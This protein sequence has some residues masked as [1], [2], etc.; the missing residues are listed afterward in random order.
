MKLIKSIVFLS[1][2]AAA[3]EAGPCQSLDGNNGTIQ[4]L[5]S[6][7]CGSG[8][9]PTAGSCQ[10]DQCLDVLGAPTDCEAPS[11][12]CGD[13]FCPDVT[14]DGTCFCDDGE[15][16]QLELP[17]DCSV[18]VGGA[19]NCDGGGFITSGTSTSETSTTQT[20]TSE[21]STSTTTETTSSSSSTYEAGPCQELVG[22]GTVE[23]LTS[24]PCGDNMCAPTTGSCK[25]GQCLDLF[26][27]PTECET[28]TNKCGDVFCPVVT[29]GGTCY[30]SSGECKQ[31]ELPCRCNNW[32]GGACNCKGSGAGGAMGLS[33]GVA[34]V[35]GGSMLTLL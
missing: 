8:C 7:P 12:Q 4:C 35:V 10:D 17:C 11:N 33:V 6:T 15:C 21:T 27:K 9:A 20:S 24:R 3:Y 25:N 5:T 34:L 32:V 1:T 19:C 23:C 31:L 29:A 13:V 22:S 30:C 14:A 16:K 26:D 28:P 18:W 2:A